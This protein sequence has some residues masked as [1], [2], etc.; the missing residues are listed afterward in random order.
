MVEK[1]TK[2]NKYSFLSVE[3]GIT[4]RS[5]NGRLMGDLRMGKNISQ[6]IVAS[7]FSSLL[8]QEQEEISLNFIWFGVM[9]GSYEI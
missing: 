6:R 4:I 3:N 8:R 1:K 5:E 9:E 2:E 7:W